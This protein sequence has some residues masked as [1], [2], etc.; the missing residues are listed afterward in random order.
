MGNTFN[1]SKFMSFVCDQSFFFLLFLYL[2]VTNGTW[3]LMFI[4]V[5]VKPRSIA[6]QDTHTH[7]HTHT[8]IIKTKYKSLCTVI[9]GLVLFYFHLQIHN[10]I[11]LSHSI[12]KLVNYRTVVERV[13][14]PEFDVEPVVLFP[15]PVC[16][17]FIGCHQI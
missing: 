10:H 6:K 14:S 7:T 13:C 17:L 4:H 15:H 5:Q 1:A 16:Q 9:E 3:T 8:G 2:N 11:T 12:P